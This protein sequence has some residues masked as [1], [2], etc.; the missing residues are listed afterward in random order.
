MNIRTSDRAAV[1]K[2]LCLMKNYK[3]RIYLLIVSMIIA[4]GLNLVMPLLSRVLMDDGFI[5]GNKE[6]AIRVAVLLAGIQIINAFIHVESEKNRIYISTQM[7]Y[8]L[9]CKAFKHLLYIKADYYDRTNNAEILNV[10]YTDIGNMISITDRGVFFVFTQFFSI[11]GGSIGL[12]VIDRKMAAFVLLFLPV[13]FY[14]MKYFAKKQ[15]KIMNSYIDES[16]ECSKWFGDMVAGIQEIKLFNMEE[17]KEK[18]F[19]E[20]QINVISKKK[21]MSINGQWNTSTDQIILEILTMFLY[22]VGATQIFSYNTSIGSVFAFITYSCYVTAPISSI[23]NIRYMLAGIVPSTKRFYKF[24]DIEEEKK[25]GFE[26]T[27]SNGNLEFQ[28]VRFS[29]NQND[30]VL[31]EVSYCF[32]QG[33]KTAIIGE[34]GAGKST[35]IKLIT[36]IYQPENGMIIFNGK[37]IN[38]YELSAYRSL[39]AVVSQQTYLFD[40][41][42][43][44]NIVLYKKVRDEDLKDILIDCGLSEFVRE[45]GLEYKVGRD[46]ALLSGGQKQKIALARV[47]IQDKPIIIFDEV[48]SNADEKSEMRLN[49]LFETRLKDKTVLVITH[50][51][52]ILEVVDEVITLENGRFKNFQEGVLK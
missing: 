21:K 43:R 12:F 31:Q 39:I 27:P 15:K 42:I 48:T 14:V 36:R 32:T 6:L 47:L 49:S 33:S 4:T 52:E 9:L 2:L 25:E 16:R 51:K 1:Y 35:L 46:G 3:G 45:V 19:V 23:L 24:I 18:E 28:K 8:N 13:K 40:S 22:I 29:Y 10:L 30:P 37:N 50:R 7:E 5:G 11:I 44:E 26:K 17:Q 41:S 20:K 38:E 34:N